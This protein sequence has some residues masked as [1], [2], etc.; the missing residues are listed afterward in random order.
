[1]IQQCDAKSKFKRRQIEQGIGNITPDPV[2]TTIDYSVNEFIRE[3]D[4]LVASNLYIQKQFK[5]HAPLIN[6]KA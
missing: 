6:V 4:S 2:I 5:E 3:H 1:M